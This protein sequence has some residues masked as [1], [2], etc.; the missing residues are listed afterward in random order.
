M[1]LKVNAHLHVR[2]YDQTENPRP[3]YVCVELEKEV[4]YQTLKKEMD[5]Y[6]GITKDDKKVIKIRNKDGVLIPM[7]E[8]LKG[9]DIN[10]PFI[11]DISRIHHSTKNNVNLLQDAYLDA[12]RQKIAS[13]ESRINQAE[14]LVPQLQWRR[15]AHMDDT[16][17]MLSYRVSFL[18]R[19]IDELV[20]EEWKTKMPR[21]MS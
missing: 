4:D 9:N 14:L 18:N 16:V 5:A 13:M 19:R 7:M 8:I 11:I 17:S 10:S 1:S 6:F 2:R 20:P 21:K 12:I 3:K 15:Q